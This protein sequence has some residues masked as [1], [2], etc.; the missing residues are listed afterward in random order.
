[1]SRPQKFRL[2][3]LLVQDKLITE[4]QL[5]HALGEQRGSG[6]KLGELLVDQGLITEAQIA[7]AVARQLHAPYID[8]AYFPVRPE[9]A[10]LLPEA[11]ARRMRAIVLDDPPSGLMVGMADPTDIYVFD[12]IG[13]LLKRR[14]DLAVI[15]ETHLN[16]ALDRVYHSTEEI[17]GLARELTS[18]LAGAETDLGDLLGMDST[19]NEDAPVARLLYSVFEQALRLRASDIHIEPQEKQL[20]IRFRI[21]GVL[22]VQTEADAKISAAVALRLKLM[23]GLDISEKRLPQDGRFAVRLKDGTVDIRISTMPA[24]YGES[25]VMR[26]LS[27][28]TGMLDLDKMKM[29]PR[30]LTALRRAIDK[31]SGMILVTGPTGSGK[32]TTLYGALNALNSTERKIITVEDPVEY[33]LPGLNQVQVMEKIDL[34]FDRVLR[35]ALRQDPDVI[36]VGE[37]RDKA[38][39]EIGL[40]AAMTGHLVL[41]TLHTNDAASTPARLIDMGVPRWMVALSLQLVVAQR[42]VRTL[43]SACAIPH[44][45]TPQEL[46]WLRGQL[47]DEADNATFKFGKG[48]PECNDSGFKGRTGVYEFL[49]MTLGLIDALNHPEPG[50]FAKAARDNMGRHTLRRDAARLVV[51]GRTTVD[52]AMRVSAEVDE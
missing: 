46:V 25:V 42:L 9:L 4:A 48:C 21:D 3:D 36:L 37:I 16:A 38:T 31:P 33:R 49:E 6:R 17:E 10:Q 35:A 5:T 14:I 23:S 20:R 40:R 52:E 45:P 39:A 12:E 30:M 18:E 47:G 27:Q 26:L 15:T 41:S 29:P 8:L 34:G 24:Q 22:H 28:S 50:V 1:M 7:K 44:Q 32:T 51:E 11:H 19:S 2:G 43:C 13:R